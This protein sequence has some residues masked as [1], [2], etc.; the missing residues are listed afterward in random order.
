MKANELM[1]G[2]WI[3]VTAEE[4]IVN[5]DILSILPKAGKVVSIDYDCI[6]VDF[7]EHPFMLGDIE[8]IPLTPEILEKNG[9][10]VKHPESTKRIYWKD[11]AGQIVGHKNRGLMYMEISGNPV[12]FG[13]FLPHF[14]GHI[15]FVH[16]FQHAIRLCRSEKEIEL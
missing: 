12:K 16:E 6:Y 14:S 4:N 3:N 8:P 13:Y 7:V 15:Q 9:F 11:R 2:D 5:P 10:I 1:I